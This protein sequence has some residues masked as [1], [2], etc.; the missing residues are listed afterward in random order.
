VFNTP[1]GKDPLLEFFPTDKY[2][3]DGT[4]VLVYWM[5][6]LV[7]QS[8]W[9]ITH[10]ISNEQ[11]AH[12]LYIIR[13]RVA[14][15][16]RHF[17]CCPEVPAGNDTGFPAAGA[18][19]APYKR[20]QS[21]SGYKRGSDTGGYPQDVRDRSA[22]WSNSGWDQNTR[23]GNADSWGSLA[24]QDYPGGWAGNDPWKKAADHAEP[25]AQYKSA[26]YNDADAKRQTS[27]TRGEWAVKSDNNTGELHSQ[28]TD[29]KRTSAQKWGGWTNETGSG[30]SRRV[31]LSRRQHCE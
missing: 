28:D 10:H 3:W 27:H 25:W 26:T 11:A 7:G 8:R 12:F 9:T 13:N 30:N 2:K 6:D 22:T 20:S 21:V 31:F 16:V 1:P 19:P 4:E 15:D 17:Q 5:G 14:S 18:K 23:H 29:A 24:K